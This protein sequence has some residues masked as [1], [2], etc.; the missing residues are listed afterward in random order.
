[1]TSQNHYDD[2]YFE[3]QSHV[4]M[5]GAKANRIKFENL[6]K[7]KDKVLDFGCGGGYMLSTFNNIEKFGVEIN[8]AATKVA[9]QNLK[10][11]KS[12]KN[13]PDNFFDI[14]ISNHA[15]EHCDNPFI[16]LKELHRSLKKN[17][18]ICIV[19]PIDN[20]KNL[21]KKNDRFFHLYSWSPSNLGNILSATGFDVIES[22]PFFHK[23]I[24]H[25][26]K[27]KRILPWP[28]FHFFC[29]IYGRLNHD[30]W[31]TRAIAKKI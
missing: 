29:R 5:F 9:M 24:P 30:W 31:Q 25:Y 4:G 10:V 23:W 1:M 11:F 3:W 22:K 26:F 13:L 14:I 7:P 17:G 18:L 8:D 6:I 20:K 27:V 19:V 21:F 28:V 15:L 2:K 16:E 12:S